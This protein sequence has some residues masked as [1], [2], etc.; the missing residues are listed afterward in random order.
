MTASSCARSAI[1]TTRG[2]KRLRRGC[3]W[4]FGRDVQQGSGSAGAEHQRAQR[5]QCGVRRSRRRS[6][7]VS[8]LTPYSATCWNAISSKQRHSVALARSQPQ[9]SADWQRNR[10]GVRVAQLSYRVCVCD[11]CREMSAMESK[12]NPSTN[13]FFPSLSLASFP[14]ESS[15]GVKAATSSRPRV[16]CRFLYQNPKKRLG[17][18]MRLTRWTLFPSPFVCEAVVAED[19]GS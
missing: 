17:V 19:V 4:S 2:R 5:D 8:G 7:R 11:K 14:L 3:A 18:E 13:S 10:R 16:K 15:H 6:I 9:A 1:V 12:R